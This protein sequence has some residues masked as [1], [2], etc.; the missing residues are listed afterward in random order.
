MAFPN[1][2][3]TNNYSGKAANFFLVDEMERDYS[4][5]GEIAGYPELAI[6][7]P[8][9]RPGLIQ[10]QNGINRLPRVAGNSTFNPENIVSLVFALLPPRLIPILKPTL[11]LEVNVARLQGRLCGTTG[12]ERYQ[13]FLQQL[14]IPSNLAAL[15]EEYHL[16]KY[17]L[18][19]FIKQW[20][21][22]SLEFLERLCQDWEK[23]KLIFSPETDPGPLVALTGEV[24]DSHR[25]GRQV[26]ILEFTSG[27]KLV[28]KPKALA[29]DLHF[30]ELL[31][32]LNQRSNFLPFRTLGLLD[33]GTYGWVEFIEAVECRT[34]AEV[35]RFYRRQ[36]GLLA[37]LYTLEGTDIH[38]ENLV[39]EGEHP[40][41]IDLETLFHPRKG[42]I[43]KN[44]TWDP[45][46][47]ALFNSVLRVG[48]LPGRSV[49]GQTLAGF[50]LNGLAGPA[51]RF[52]SRP[53]P[54][55]VD[56]GTDEMRVA[57]Q[58]VKISGGGNLPTLTNQKIV[59]IDYL[60]DLV[61]GFKIIYTL[62]IELREPL[63]DGPLQAFCHDTCRFIARPTYNY[64]ILRQQSFHPNLL[65]DK[66][67]QDLL[68]DHLKDAA[69]RQPHLGCLAQ[70]EKIDLEEGDI[71]I[72]TSQLDTTNLFTSRGEI[73]EH[74][75]ERSGLAGA[76]RR[77]QLLNL[78]DLGQQIR[79]IRTSIIMT[80]PA[81]P[82]NQWQDTHLISAFDES[83]PTRLKQAALK[84]GNRL[85]ET[86]CW[87]G[88]KVN[89]V[90]F[91]M[92]GDGEWKLTALRS[93]LY[94]GTSGIALFLAYLGYSTQ[95]PKYTRLAKAAV[96]TIYQQVELEIEQS[97]RVSIGVFTG[98]SGPVY[99]F[100]HLAT[101]WNDRTLLKQAE[102]WVEIIAGQIEFDTH[103]DIIDGSAGCI[104]G[105]LNFY[106]VSPSPALLQTALACGNHLLAPLGFMEKGLNRTGQATN[107]KML[108]G[109]S[110]GAAGIALSLLRLAQVSGDAR[111]SNFARIAIHFEREL[112]S[113]EKHNWP[114]LRD[115]EK[116]VKEDGQTS[117][118]FHYMVSWCHGAPGIGLARLAG[119]PCYPDD[120]IIPEIK[121][122]LFTT[123]ADGFGFNFSLCHGDLGNLEILLAASLDL[124]ENGYSTI[125]RQYIAVI[126]ERIE[127]GGWV[128]GTPH[129]IET[130]GLMNGLAGIGYQL[131]RLSSP[132][133]I[134]SVLVLADPI[135]PPNP[136]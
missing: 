65:R 53:F 130:P 1:N 83:L 113:S 37:L 44:L 46:L 63:I 80:G 73:I 110:H 34:K 3:F 51:G 21:A 93:D 20:V 52:S 84:V 136:G 77:L 122:A 128:C 121:V 50:D 91:N 4:L 116:S 22:A 70:A 115:R 132:A 89:W 58:P 75:F 24:A 105:L 112:F 82:A 13:F 23:I 54:V 104:L 45:A 129:G 10:L 72:F 31:A 107:R 35:A 76:I 39:A 97:R 90:G 103:F 16:L 56:Q 127:Y 33:R 27:L 57:R 41:L 15:F 94:N 11:A 86:A 126:L 101:L 9:L 68:F 102:K 123:L 98:L 59:L 17:Q 14:E 78:Q 25:K 95:D 134:P 87:Q 48:L 74:F 79:L 62:L 117:D 36:G 85:V 135:I 43:P 7:K 29:L 125:L 18:E 5:P 120:S 6:L 106:R 60:D 26:L 133:R 96:K 8:L 42:E 28:Y 47:N 109:F 111:F 99:L 131:L 30:Q 124:A 19:L 71:P 40:V 61:D 114:D 119:L 67:A 92:V 81:N 108:A 118:N 32:W 69:A 55:L 12:A 100:S 49:S 2:L 88:D 66:A 38:Y 64:A